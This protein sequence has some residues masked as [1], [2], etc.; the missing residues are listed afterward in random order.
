MPLERLT[1]QLFCAAR[2]YAIAMRERDLEA[3]LDDE[4]ARVPRQVPHTSSNGTLSR[5]A[6]NG[7]ENDQQRASRFE[8]I[9]AA[10]EFIEAQGSQRTG[11]M[12]RL[13]SEVVA[14]IKWNDLMSTFSNDDWIHE[15]LQ[16]TPDGTFL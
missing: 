6:G 8:P 16:E 14:S 11:R 2:A 3:L 5:A 9:V 15:M 4:P 10:L 13:L 7:T 12:K 1:T